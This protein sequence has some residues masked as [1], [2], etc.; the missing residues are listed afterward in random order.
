MSSNPGRDSNPHDADV[1]FDTAM[2]LIG[3][4][5]KGKANKQTVLLL[6]VSIFL[7]VML[8]VAV[9]FLSVGTIHQNN[10]SVKTQYQQCLVNNTARSEDKMLWE[11]F[12]ADATPPKNKI[13]PKIT[14]ELAHLSMLVNAKDVPRDCARLYPQAVRLR[15]SCSILTRRT[16]PVRP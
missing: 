6:A 1:L 3:K 14:A 4:L 9:I 12:L 5:Q 15:M 13:T 16:S 8:S 2:V 11:V 10:G 7:D